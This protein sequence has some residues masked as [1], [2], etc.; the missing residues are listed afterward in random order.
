[1]RSPLSRLTILGLVVVIALGACAPIIA[2]FSLEAYKNAT[3]LKAETMAL[4]DKSGGK[5]S[6]H[7]KEIE[8]NTTKINAA[9]EFAAGLAANSL[10]A[11]QW[12]L[13]RNPD[14][15]LYGGFI[16]VWKKQ[17]TTSPAYRNAKK[18]QI[19]AAF[20]TIICLESNKR[21]SIGCSAVATSMPTG[22][23]R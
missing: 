23:G 20:D 11:Q 12:N 9:Y 21:E 1:M 19:A 15:N 17:G 18:A 5:Y 16:A 6:T 4:V 13:L 22:G 14:G 10:S 8:E 7:S 3:S 2:E